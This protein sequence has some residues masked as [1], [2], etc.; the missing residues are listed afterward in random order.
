MIHISASMRF[1]LG[2]ALSCA[3]AAWGQ[4]P[5]GII[6]GVVQDPSGAV[7]VGAIITITNVASGQNRVLKSGADGA[8]AA[9]S[10]LAGNYEVTAT[11]PGFRTTVR[12]APVETGATTT[13][14]MRLQVGESREIVTVEAATSQIEYE[15]HTIDA[16]VGTQQ[17][18]SLPLN[19]RNFLQLAQLE[20]GVSVTTAGLGQYNKQFDVNILGAGSESVRI[21]VDGA[22]IND[23]INGGAQQNFS[24]EMVQEFQLSSVNFDL[25]TGITGGGAVNIITRSG[26]NAFHGAG[27]F[28]FRDHNMA[29]YP[30]L[31]RDPVN[32]DPFFVRRQPGFWLGGPVKKDR[33][34]FFANY[35]YMNQRGAY[36]AVPSSP[37]FRAFAANATAPY[38]ANLV[39]VRLDAHVGDKHSLFLR[40]GHDGNKGFAPNAVTGGTQPSNWGVNWNYSDSGVFSITSA[41]RP[42][43]VNEFRYSMTYWHNEKT[44]PTTADC[45]PP[46]VGLGLPQISVYQVNGLQIGNDVINTPQSRVVRRHI[47]ADNITVQKGSHGIR[48]GGEL[49]FEKGTGTY[50]YGE[51]GGMVLYSPQ[52]VQLYNSQ[53]PPPFRLGLPGSFTTVQD[54]LQLPVLGF[55]TGVGDINQPP[56]Y[57]RGEAD[58]NN[59]LHVYAQ[60]T[61]R[62]HPRF[63]LNY[64]LAYSFENGT[65]NFDLTR[66]SYL[67]PILGPT[68]LGAPQHD[69]LNFSP[70]VGFAWRATEDGKTVVRGGG[71]IYYDSMTLTVRLIER[72]ALGP[73]GTGRVL[74]DD[75]F[76]FPA[77]AQT[78]HFDQLPPPLQPTSLRGGPT[79]FTGAMLVAS[80][81]QLRAAAATQLGQNPNN[82]DLSVRNV[83]VFKTSPSGDMMVSDFRLPVVEHASIGV[84]RELRSGLVVS[85]DFVYR[86]S[87][88]QRIRNTDLNHYRSV[89]GPVIPNCAG[90]QALDPLAQ[91][92]TGPIDFDVSGGSSVYKGLLVRLDK[93]F[94]HR[95]QLTASYA[96]QSQFGYNELPGG[97]TFN[98]VVVD[99]N[100]WRA[101]YG[102][103]A[104]H[105]ILTVSG[106]VHLPLG[107]Q[108][109]LISSFQSKS[110]FQP[111]IPRINVENGQNIQPLPDGGYNEFGINRG[112]DELAQLVSQYNQTYASAGAPMMRLPAQYSLGRTFTSQD[113]RLTKIF[114]FTEHLDL[115]V[116]GEV[117]N[118]FNIANFNVGDY[119]NN[120]ANPGFGEPT[121]RAGQLFGSGGP[122]A[123]QMGAR[124]Q[125]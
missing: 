57:N 77:I 88:H 49:E 7:V 89:N 76:F 73:A 99:Y 101:G 34:F 61:W 112:K 54:L 35:E 29:A 119:G 42:N 97:G 121:A 50:A 40:Y 64:G 59:R 1:A 124:F 70:A 43:L 12:D 95:F 53:I 3:I 62:L 8:F 5:T 26:S 18:Q 31:R 83:Q 103:Q 39:G 96:L 4:A 2:I 30:Y 106:F 63:T 85:A 102:P 23:S 75:S 55:V 71:G 10:L 65:K 58:H 116:F 38:T 115:R 81:P 109:S 107:L 105:N 69:S 113:F 47:F 84:Q 100:N 14:E 104:P 68:G 90:E 46:C 41:L 78:L 48:F 125:F 33:L 98:S 17:I 72:G 51:P 67:E 74:L 108:L 6:S 19:G 27:F 79:P 122:R 93:R 91:C 37:E 120:L 16:V 82:T 94:A 80:L 117:F 60:D 11:S 15:R 123:F 24:Q 25:S 52:I 32:P 92:S 21:T 44:P 56:T 20:P 114:R 66:P 118:A 86:L 111:F 110:P 22:T 28:Y 36:G 9:A 87:L 13:V 45:P